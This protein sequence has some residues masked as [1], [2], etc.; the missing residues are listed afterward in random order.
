MKTRKDLYSREAAE[1]LRV[2]SEYKT[3]LTEQI[4]RLFP[5]K[6]HIVKI[7]LAYLV[8]QGRITFN[9]GAARYSA[10]DDKRLSVPA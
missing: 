8:K 10:N 2:V 6:G 1:L 7:L 3:L 4:Y 5:G 9:P